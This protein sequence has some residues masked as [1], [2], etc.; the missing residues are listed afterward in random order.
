M[1]SSNSNSIKKTFNP[2]ILR[3]KGD[4]KVSVPRSLPW[5]ESLGREENV[6]FDLVRCNLYPSSIEGGTAEGVGLRVANS[7]TGNHRGDDFTP[8]E[9]IRRFLGII[10]SRSLSSLKGRS[11]IQWGGAPILS[12]S[13]G[14]ENFVVYCDALHKGLGIVFMQ[15]EKVIAY[16]SRQLKFHDKN[17]TTNDLELGAVVFA[18][19]IW[20]HLE[21]EIRY[22]PRKANVVEDALS[23]K[24]RIKPL[25][26]RALVMT[27]NLNLPSQILS[28]QAEAMKEE[29]VKEENLH[30]MD[31]E[32]ETRP[33]GTLCIRNRSW[34]PRFRELRDLIMHESHKSKYSIHPGSD[35]MYHDLK[36][37]Y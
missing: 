36:K 21:L 20:R 2:N 5:R 1:S 27:I 31:K 23:Q 11:S 29:N 28:A 3:F 25:R 8:L 18:L 6:S 33:D 22:H 26:V 14:I 37:L 10:R 32:F 35:K 17:Y 13:E 34:L 24:E 19:K 4:S 30:D 9:T 7:H 16:A 15:K 12:L